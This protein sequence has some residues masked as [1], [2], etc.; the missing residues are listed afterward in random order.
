MAGILESIFKLLGFAKTQYDNYQKSE[1]GN[2]TTTPDVSYEKKRKVKS[3]VRKVADTEYVQNLRVGRSWILPKMVDMCFDRNGNFSESNYYNSISQL[4]HTSCWDLTVRNYHALSVIC[5]KDPKAFSERSKWWNKE[6]AVAMAQADLELLKTQTSKGWRVYH[7]CKGGDYIYLP[8]LRSKTSRYS[9]MYFLKTPPATYV[10]QAKSKNETVDDLYLEFSKRID[11]IK[12]A[13]DPVSLYKAV[14]DY[15]WNRCVQVGESMPDAFVNAYA[16][17]GA[18][19][20]MMTMV[21]Y[22]GLTF[23]GLDRDACI[24]AIERKSNEVANDGRQ[25][26]AYCAAKFFDK[27]AGGVFEYKDYKKGG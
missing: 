3:L 6:V 21:K 25:L 2:Y 26:F 17:D 1:K 15:D 23:D 13:S 18:Y 7:D 14:R 11:A 8:T 5:Q 22:L 24:A 9:K 19:S 12:C 10:N 16:G 4:D 27:N 20:A